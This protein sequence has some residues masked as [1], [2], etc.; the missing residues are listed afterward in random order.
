MR[1]AIPVVDTTPSVV[2]N[3]ERVRGAVELPQREPGF[4][5]GR[6]RLWI[7]PEGFHARQVEHDGA[8]AH[9]VPG[10]AVTAPAH[11]EREVVSTCERDAAAHVG[12]INSPDHGERA[13]IDHAVEHRAG[14]VVATV[15][16]ADHLPPQTR[17]EL[18]TNGTRH[19]SDVYR[20]RAT[21][22]IRQPVQPD[23]VQRSGAR[24]ALDAPHVS[25]SATNM[26]TTMNTVHP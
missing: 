16:G 15:A 2:A 24:R 11:R 26:Q 19:P 7:N 9:G 21:P 10:D 12:R 5:P 22:L 3:P 14:R 23:T 20:H 25:Q 18:P 17:P 1:P 8:V 13:P 6:P 4:G